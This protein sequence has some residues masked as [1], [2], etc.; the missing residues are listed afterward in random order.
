MI[1][2]GSY[3]RLR[4]IQLAYDFDKKFLEKTFLQSLRVYLNAQNPFT[5]AYNSGFTPEAGGTPI[6]FGKDTGGYPLPA[7]TSFG[8][9]LT[10]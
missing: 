7:I 6:S 3:L 9:N 2:D 5:W 1:E 4:N 10:F 8:L